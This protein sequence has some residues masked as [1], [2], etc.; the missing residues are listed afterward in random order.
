MKQLI[1]RCPTF[2]CVTHPGPPPFNAGIASILLEEVW[3]CLGMGQKNHLMG[4]SVGGEGGDGMGGQ[5][6]HES[7]GS[8]ALA[9]GGRGKECT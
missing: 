4:A 6:R 7:K 5:A 3:P 9:E 1:C 2:G 8:N